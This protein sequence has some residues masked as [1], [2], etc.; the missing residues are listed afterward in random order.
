MERRIGCAA[1]AA[2]LWTAGAAVPATAET[3]V[4]VANRNAL[5]HSS[6]KAIE[7]VM[8]DVLNQVIDRDFK[9]VVKNLA[10]EDRAR[11]GDLSKST[12]DALK[13]L[14]T[15]MKDQWKAKYGHAMDLR[16]AQIPYDVTSGSTDRVATVKVPASAQTAETTLRL[17]NE[18]TVMNAWRVDIPDTIDNPSL[19]M[20]LESA[21]QGFNTEFGKSSMDEKTAYRELAARVFRALNGSVS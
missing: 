1:L 3:T 11:L 6:Q 2:V 15:A 9:G 4:P 21:V 5:D 8:T 10:K 18:G 17:V 16:G 20:T 13:T 7:S 19:K 14:V 12:P